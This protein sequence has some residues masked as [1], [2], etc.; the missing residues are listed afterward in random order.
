MK[1]S[2]KPFPVKCCSTKDVIFTS[3]PGVYDYDYKME[4]N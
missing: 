3:L 2:Y 1:I 4:Q